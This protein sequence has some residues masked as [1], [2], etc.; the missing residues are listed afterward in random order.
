MREGILK[1]FEELI[2]RGKS[3]PSAASVTLEW[4]SQF[5]KWELSCL[6]I[7]ET[8]FG[9]DSEYYTRLSQ[10]RNFGNHQAWVDYGIAYMESAKEEIEKGFL[11]KIEHLISADFFDSIL[12]HAEYLLS[13]GHKDPAAVLGRVVIEKTLKQIA[14][15]QN[16]VLSDKVKLAEVNELLWKNQVYDKITWRL[17]QGHIDLGNFAAHGDF[18][19]YDD[20]KVKDMLDW[21]KKN[22]MSM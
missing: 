21:V 12:E 7:L 18:D 11:Y 14:E 19:E 22:L 3:L 2:G 4:Q 6:N 5:L 8:T 9:K 15:R 16:I 20:N 1:R 10:V 13:K 17:V